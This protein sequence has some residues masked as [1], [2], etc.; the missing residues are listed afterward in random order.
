[1]MISGILITCPKC[2]H[3]FDGAILLS[4]GTCRPKKDSELLSKFRKCENCSYDV[5]IYE[6]NNG[7]RAFIF[8][9]K[10]FSEKMRAWFNKFLP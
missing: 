2:Q 1:M 4:M 9:P 3:K 6:G 10:T 5:D 8:P 7:K